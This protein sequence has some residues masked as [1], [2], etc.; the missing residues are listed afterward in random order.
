M[1]R[2]KQNNILVVVV[3]DVPDQLE[4]MRLLLLQSGYDVLTATN[5]QQGFE[6]A[7]QEHPDLVISDVSLPRMD[8]IEMCRRI[9]QHPDLRLTPVLLVSAIPRDNES[10]SDG[11]RAGADDY[12]EAP[13][14]PL[15]LIA[16]V[17]R[18][19]ERRRAEAALK[20]SED[21]IR[22]II[23]T[24]PVMAWSSRPDGTVDF[25]N[26]RWVDYA[27]L[28]LEQFV[29]DP[30]API[31][32]QDT[33]RVMEKWLA[34][35]ALGE[36]YEDEMRLRRADGEYRWFLVRNAPLRD[37]SGKVIKWYGVSTDIDD[38]KRAEEQLRRAEEQARNVI[39][40]I[41]QQIWS[42]P[43]GGTLDYCN[44]QWRAYAGL[45][46]E[47]LQGNGWQR[48]LHP[49]DKERVLKAWRESVINGTPYEQEERH[50]RAD[51]MYRWFLCR[52]VPL[53]GAEGRI[54]RWYGTNTDIEDRKRAGETLRK[55][56]KRFRALV[57]NSTDGISL[58]NSEGAVVYASPATERVF[59]LTMEEMQTLR[60]DLIH[61]DD[62]DK[63]LNTWNELHATPG[64]LIS[65]QYRVRYKDGTWRWLEVT[66]HSLFSDPSVQALVVNFRDITERKQ[67]EALLVYQANL[68]AN[69]HDAILATDEQYRLTAWN[70][71]AE[72]LYGWKAEEVLGR[73]V[74]E[75]TGIEFTD[76]QRAE[77]LKGLAETGYY[78]TEVVHHRRDGTP[79]YVQ[80]YTIT[81]RDESGRITGY[82]SAN[83]DITERKQ[84]EDALR[85]S[86]D[87]LRLVIDTIPTM[88]WSL[89]PDG[90][91]D[92]VNQRWLDYTG[93]SLEE[94]LEQPNR[95]VYPEDISRV[96]ENWLPDMAAGEPS[97]DE[98][99]LQRADGQ[100]RWFLVRTV[101]LRDEQGNIV[102]WY[103]ASSDIQERQQAEE[104]LRQ[105]E[106]Q[107]AEAQRLAHIGS[108]NWDLQNNTLTWSEEH[109][110]IFG[111]DPQEYAPAYETAV[112]KSIHPEDREFVRRSIE[113]S[114]RTHEPFGYY[115]RIIRP[116]GKMRVIHSRGNVVSDEQGTPIRIFGMAQD[117][118]ERRLA[119]EQLKSSNEKLRALSTR[120]QAARE[121]ESLRIAREIH[122]EMGGALTG[123][124]IDLSWLGKRL[125][126]P[127]HE[128]LHQKL[129]SMAE[130]IDE[131]I[132]QVR[133]I[134]SQLRP[135]VLDD[136]GLAAAIE[137]L[138]S[139]F[140]KRSGTRC[141]IIALAEDIT[142][143]PEKATAVFRIFQEIVTNI[144]RHANATLVEIAMTESEGDLVLKVSDNGR[145]IKESENADSKSLGLLGMRERALVFGGRVDITGIEGQGT[146]VVVSIP[147][148]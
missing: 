148:A 93:L 101:P 30:M 106:S 27:G 92:F 34:R 54:E 87:H 20:Q 130:L 96:L 60:L 143:S 49:D 15:H 44:Y 18:L 85:R 16:K 43:A 38:R 32:P 122:D 135:S 19:L 74:R 146:T 132:Q 112:T 45:G 80:G 109:Y 138:A 25:L 29:A 48:M 144:A 110:H 99:R 111:L 3:N 95:V 105:S 55:A 89:R 56:E 8:G 13:Y 53:R 47:E 86:E 114:L 36:E 145:G 72:E 121:E 6:A 107:L 88:V 141:K 23:D 129:K 33:P 69:V 41:P 136:L 128:A 115:F 104:K 77:A 2:Q 14:D 82:V 137:W 26:Q 51:G 116:D 64:K 52:G 133:N 67:A 126:K 120:L 35:M 62:H 12:L 39:D 28:S 83:R 125:N 63:V 113:N 134:S 124:K 79:L 97:E 103:G 131:T 59:G 123:L 10:V 50:R 22:L 66:A 90:A 70:R 68:L 46:L 57:E 65:Y 75:V 21:R 108:W 40:A 94:S 147:R 98:M 81:L 42:G 37:E 31:H 71:A 100:Y 7:R 9:R 91:V 118:T 139:E 11:M 24:I 61:P 78:Q 17:E 140:Q 58:I 117:V 1:R 127:G 142:L 84:A 4:I 5:G 102:K 119:E 73:Q 76:A